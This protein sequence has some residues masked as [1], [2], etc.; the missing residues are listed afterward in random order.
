[1]P[2]LRL[3]ALVYAA[4]QT[5]HPHPD[6]LP[7]WV[8]RTAPRCGTGVPPAIVSM[9]PQEADHLADLVAHAWWELAQDP[10]DDP[11][12]TAL[13]RVCAAYLA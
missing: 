12:T 4:L 6:A 3:P 11:I 5:C 13:T 9:T 2:T 10:G 7:A 8:N 1:M